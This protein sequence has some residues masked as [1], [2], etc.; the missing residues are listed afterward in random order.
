MTALEKSI[1]ALTMTSFVAGMAVGALWPLL[2]LLGLVSG[3]LL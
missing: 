2:V 1:L 3:G